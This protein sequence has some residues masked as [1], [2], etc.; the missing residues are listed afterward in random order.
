M[1]VRELGGHHASHINRAIELSRTHLGTHLGGPFGCVVAKDGVIVS[2][3]CNTVVRDVDPTCHAE[4]NA[5]RQACKKLGRHDLSD[6]TIYSS[7]EPCPMCF[8]AIHWSKIPEIYYCNTRR[9]AA[10]I[11]FSDDHIYS[12]IENKDKGMHHVLSEDALHV[13]DEWSRD[14]S[15]Q[16][17]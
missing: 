17:Y 13:F 5:I 1:D 14:D 8:A 12:L 6:C 2:E 7:C 15:K 16:L 10:R 4:I 11:G 9:D 3:G